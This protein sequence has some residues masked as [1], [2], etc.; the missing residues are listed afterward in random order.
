MNK[1]TKFLIEV[2][3]VSIGG[4]IIGS[5]FSK[6]KELR[7]RN[8]MLEGELENSRRFIRGL[9]K[10][11]EMLSYNLGKLADRKSNKQF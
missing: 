9:Q 3:V 10:S 4:C 7:Q 6:N 1:K 11:N 2:V 5:I 8:Q